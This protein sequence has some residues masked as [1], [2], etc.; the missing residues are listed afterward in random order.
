MKPEMVLPNF[1]QVFA[2]MISF[3]TCDPRHMLSVPLTCSGSFLPLS[4]ASQQSQSQGVVEE[5]K[6]EEESEE[7]DPEAVIKV[8]DN[9]NSPKAQETDGEGASKK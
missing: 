6:M 4:S 2:S 1:S 3:T 5:N 9:K 8:R 7:S